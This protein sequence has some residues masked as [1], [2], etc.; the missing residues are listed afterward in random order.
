M[1]EIGRYKKQRWEALAQANVMSSRLALELDEQDGTK[2][3][4]EFGHTF[5]AGESFHFALN[6]VILKDNRIPPCKRACQAVPPNFIQRI[7]RHRL[8]FRLLVR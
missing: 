1:D 7:H 4:Q 5:S 6:Y 8:D 3:P 2:G